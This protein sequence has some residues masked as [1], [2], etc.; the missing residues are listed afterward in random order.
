M[1]I[2]IGDRLILKKSHP[3]G[4]NLWEV[5]RVGQDFRIRCTGCGH[6]LMIARRALE[7]SIRQVKSSS[8]DSE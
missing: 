1:N 3:C 5:I 4:S 7:K 2:K 8:S 6:Q